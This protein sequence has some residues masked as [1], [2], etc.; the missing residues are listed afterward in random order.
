VFVYDNYSFGQITVAARVAFWFS[1]GCRSVAVD[2]H[3]RFCE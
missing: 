3:V 1:V 2:D